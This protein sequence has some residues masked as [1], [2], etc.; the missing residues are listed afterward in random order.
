VPANLAGVWVLVAFG[1]GS[2][3]RSLPRGAARGLVTLVVAT[4]TYYALIRLTASRPSNSAIE[5]ASQIW[6]TV[7]LI[8]GPAAGLSGAAWRLRT[9]LAR[10]AGVAVVSAVQVVEGLLN[11]WRMGGSLLVDPSSGQESFAGVDPI[12]A[13]SLL[14][15]LVGLAMPIALLPVARERLIAFGSVGALA[16][17]GIPVAGVALDLLRRIASR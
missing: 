1:V 10:A 17:A 4:L 15:A 3:A 7:A 11:A 12:V 13:V 14:E 9:G 5:H 6:A 2:G 8:A 16:I